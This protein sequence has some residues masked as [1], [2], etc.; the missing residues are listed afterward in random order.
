MYNLHNSAPFC[1]ST[2]LRVIPYPNS[3]L[4][5][6]HLITSLMVPIPQTVEL[7]FA[8]FFWMRPSDLNT[9]WHLCYFANCTAIRVCSSAVDISANE[10]QR[11]WKKAFM[12]GSR[13]ERLIVPYR[14]FCLKMRLH[15]AFY[16][17]LLHVLWV[18]LILRFPG[19]RSSGCTDHRAKYRLEINENWGILRLTESEALRKICFPCHSVLFTYAFY[20]LDLPS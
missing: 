5:P 7:D 20:R 18:D 8:N 9:A 17:L 3:N 19:F 2:R 10:F 12:I 4:F 14:K 13:N 11:S 15:F 1:W 16:T 6:P